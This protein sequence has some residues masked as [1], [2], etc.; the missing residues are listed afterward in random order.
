MRKRLIIITIAV[1]VVILITGVV[2]VYL[3][4][5]PALASDF[6]IRDIDGKDIILSSYRG[7]S[8][9]ALDFM[10]IDC[11]GCEILRKNMEQI[12]PD[13]KDRVT[14]ISVDVLASD[15]IVELKDYRNKSHVSW[16]IASDT[17]DLK[18]KY[19][20]VA[21]PTLIIIDKNGY[22][23]HSGTGEPS[24]E[25]LRGIFDKAIAGSALPITIMQMSIFALAIFA[26]AASFFSP[27]SF[28]MFPGYMTLY[29]GFEQERMA[30]NQSKKDTG[31]KRR[32]FFAGSAAALGIIFVFIILG[33]LIIILGRAVA[34]Q[35]PIL[36]PI[37]GMILIVLGAL[38]FTNISYWKLVRPF[39]KL[40]GMVRR[41]KPEGEEQKSHEANGKNKGFYAKLFAY[42]MGYGAASAACVAPLFIAVISE[43]LLGSLMDGILALLL[44]TMTAALL[45]IIVTVMLATASRKAVDKLKQYTPLIKKIS[46]AVLIIVGIY[47]VTY[48]YLAWM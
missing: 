48:Y 42:G 46:A 44:Y 19:G 5:K 31:Y 40:G 35:I 4:P 14:V 2:V 25:E 37:I 27:C 26:G 15:T 20:I 12:Y 33:G 36:Q 9:V 43:A 1:V 11:P 32:A 22:P 10:Y 39:Q 28:P 41:K 24:P 6:S 21:L 29:L 7:K 34:S 18:T 17:D 30:E 23:V 13:Y 16:Q 38:M 8:V 45:M 47:L 3:W